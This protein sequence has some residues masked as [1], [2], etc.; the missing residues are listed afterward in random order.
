MRR[1]RPDERWWDGRYAQGHPNSY[2][3]DERTVEHVTRQLRDALEALEGYK[4]GLLPL[5]GLDDLTMA[6]ESL[7]DI[8]HDLPLISAWCCYTTYR[9][10]WPDPAEPPRKNV[11]SAHL[12]E[13]TAQAWLPHW[14]KRYADRRDYVWHVGLIPTRI[15]EVVH[16][17]M[18]PELRM[19]KMGPAR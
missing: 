14:Q 5:E 16:P 12:D 8:W 3:D 6:Y 13:E 4:G 19:Q 9:D 17:D 2:Y 1:E 7:H 18:T 10:G 11:W 15:I